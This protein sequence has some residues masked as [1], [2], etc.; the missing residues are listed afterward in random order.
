MAICLGLCAAVEVFLN[1]LLDIV[2]IQVQVF[3]DLDND[4][5]R[6]SVLDAHPCG[7]NL[8][9]EE[10]AFFELVYTKLDAV[11][12]GLTFRHEFTSD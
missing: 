6:L 11:I 8:R 4:S 7:G 12:I 10:Q 2:S 5:N 1:L 9:E 3:V